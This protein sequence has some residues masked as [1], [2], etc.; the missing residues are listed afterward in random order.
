[1]ENRFGNAIFS[2]LLDEIR[3]ILASKVLAT[4]LPSVFISDNE[5]NFAIVYNQA[6]KNCRHG[7]QKSLHGV[8]LSS[9]NEKV[10]KI[11]FCMEEE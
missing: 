7:K 11:N 2:G 6:N 4:G 9:D 1:M 3:P 8:H 10:F 5:Q